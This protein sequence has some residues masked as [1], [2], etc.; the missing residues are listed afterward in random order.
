MRTGGAD[1]QRKS[2]KHFPSDVMER[3]ALPVLLGSKAASSQSAGVWTPRARVWRGARAC[4]RGAHHHFF[5][6]QT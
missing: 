6:P 2:L 1:V 3:P 4:G 5:M